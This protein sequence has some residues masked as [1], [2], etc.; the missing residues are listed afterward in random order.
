[1]CEQ[2]K[3]V[4]FFLMYMSKQNK[5][6]RLWY[7]LHLCE[8]NMKPIF[9]NL[10]H[11]CEQNKKSR[12]WLL[13]TKKRNFS[14]R[15]QWATLVT[16]HFFRAHIFWQK[17]WNWTF[18]M[19]MYLLTFY[20]FD[21]IWN[22]FLNHSCE[23]FFYVKGNFPILTKMRVQPEGLNFL[24]LFWARHY[25]WWSL[26]QK[27][28]KNNYFIQVKPFFLVVEFSNTVIFWRNTRFDVILTS[29]TI[30][31]QVFLR[32]LFYYESLLDI[33]VSKH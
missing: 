28:T 10:S 17:C 18:A 31:K 26:W 7:L 8:K 33:E 32:K 1:M 2:N 5:K 22:C 23:S 14:C 24:F 29:I 19:I 4:R 13:H 6:V 21:D 30:I 3:T 12:F 15:I 11:M 27:N 25:P 9:G 20:L 16:H